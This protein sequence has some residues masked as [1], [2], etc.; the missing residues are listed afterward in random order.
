MFPGASAHMM[1]TD[2]L[3]VLMANGN[4]KIF[5]SIILFLCTVRTICL[6]IKQ[7]HSQFAFSHDMVKIKTRIKKRGS[8]PPK[9]RV[10]FPLPFLNDF[11]N[12]LIDSGMH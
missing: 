7:L 1:N 6:S 11:Y 4:M 2:E 8:K 3:E 5:L 12:V 9:K 10:F